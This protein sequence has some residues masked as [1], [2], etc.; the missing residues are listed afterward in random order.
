MTL[1]IS[2]DNDAFFERASLTK[3]EKRAMKRAEFL[4]PPS[5]SRIEPKTDNQ[6]RVFEAYAAGQNLILPGVAGTGK[7]FLSLYLALEAA[8]A[9]RE[10]KP[11]VVMRSVVPTR[12]MGFLPGGV[13]EKAAVYELP[14][15]AILKQLTGRS[16]S[17][18]K[19]K[20]LGY[21]EFSTTSY[22]RGLTFRDNTVIVDECQNMS[23]HE[24]DS[25]ITRMGDGC[26]VIFSGDFRQSDLW[27]E[28]ERNGLEKFMRICSK[29]K[30]FTR[31]EFTKDDIVR[32]DL[33]KDYIVAKLE[34]GFV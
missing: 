26:R 22:V 12:D 8:I 17:Y 2:I 24:L 11:V 5:L 20:T 6:R 25:I 16:D 14:Y 34:A 21:I 32:S 7:T 13:A 19:L 15:S 23:F 1:S 31:I 18:D 30:S 33:V 29:I 10:P 28:D 9:G 27:R 4:R 3:R